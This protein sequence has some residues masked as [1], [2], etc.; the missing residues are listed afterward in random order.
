MYMV[1]AVDSTKTSVHTHR[2]VRCRIPREFSSF[3]SRFHIVVPS[4]ILLSSEISTLRSCQLCRHEF[5]DEFF[6]LHL[7]RRGVLDPT[8]LR[9]VMTVNAA[10]RGT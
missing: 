1:K 2:P 9:G 5:S 8:E 10:I 4:D 3:F 7:R 6:L